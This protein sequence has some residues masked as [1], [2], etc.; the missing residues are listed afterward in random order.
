MNR[1]TKEV[2][3]S[4]V[5]GSAVQKKKNFSSELLKSH[6]RSSFLNKTGGAFSG[7]Q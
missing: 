6:Y 5:S 3:D 7:A 2:P 4:I 1:N